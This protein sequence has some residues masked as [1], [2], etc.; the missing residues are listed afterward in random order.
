MAPGRPGRGRQ[1]LLLVAISAVGALLVYALARGGAADPTPAPTPPPPGAEPLR[2][3][4]VGVAD[5]DTLTVADARGRRTTVRL[6]QIDTPETRDPRRPVACWGPEAARVLTDLALDRDVTVRTDPA[7]DR[8]D[9]YGRLL[10]Y[11]YRD[12]D[13]PGDPLNLRLVRE[14]DAVAWFYTGDRGRLA[15]PLLAAQQ[16]ASAAGLGLWRRCGG[17]PT[18]HAAASG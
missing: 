17:D 13:P 9:R 6:V 4:V 2:G 10:G 15:G 14:G 7:L 8:A 12:G 1:A 5:G 16:R 11:V 3:R 18:G